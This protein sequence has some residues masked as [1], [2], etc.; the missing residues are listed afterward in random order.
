MKRISAIVCTL[1]LLTGCAARP[2][3]IT[4]FAA[5]SLTDVMTELG[6]RYEAEN[7]AWDVVFNFDS[8]G[9]LRTQIDEGAECDLFLS[10]GKNQVEGMKSVDFLENRVVLIGNMGSFAELKTALEKG[11]VLLAMGNEDVPVGQYTRNILTYLG[12]DESELAKNGCITYGGNVREVLTQVKEGVAD[13][14]IVY[15]TDAAVGGLDIQDTATED[16]CGRVIYPAVVRSGRGEDFWTFL[17]SETA[18]EVLK[19]AGFTP[20]G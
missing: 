3:T 7:S 8:S 9:T 6:Q 4:V 12:L 11:E 16:M 13:C 14:G 10:A 15:A 1:L 5:S 17:Q 19:E 18:A 20:L 2:M